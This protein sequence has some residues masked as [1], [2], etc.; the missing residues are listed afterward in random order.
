MVE[1]LY[2]HT[3]PSPLGQVVLTSNGDEI[4]G[5]NFDIAPPP[6]AVADR[7]LFQPIIRQLESYF[8]GELKK[9]DIRHT[10]LGTEFQ[11]RVWKQL[12]K[13]PYGKLLCYADIAEKIGQSGASRAVGNANGKNSI[14]IIVPCHRVIAADGTL[15]GYNSGLWRKEWLLK[16]ERGEAPVHKKA[17]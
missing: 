11:R 8:A 9:F 7:K 6:N 16:L 3:Q 12:T 14:C 10:Q 13:I 1:S 4:L 2:F 15:G 5:L 17:R